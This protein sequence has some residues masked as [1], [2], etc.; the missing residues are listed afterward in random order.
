MQRLLSYIVGGLLMSSL[1][2]WIYLQGFDRLVMCY[3]MA[4]SPGGCCL[5]G[6]HHHPRLDR[7]ERNRLRVETI[8]WHA[9]NDCRQTFSIIFNI[10]LA[11]RLLL[12]EGAVLMLHL[13]GFF[14]II[15]P[16]W[17]MAPR[18]HPHV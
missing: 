3:W 4:G 18:A 5:Y 16:L 2:R 10:A 9:P 13:A 8:P 1:N 6:W 7:A 17:V 15:I 14:A 12:I 11:S